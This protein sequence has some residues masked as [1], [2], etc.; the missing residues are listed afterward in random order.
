MKQKQNHGSFEKETCKNT[1]EYIGRK[2]L[3]LTF[4]M[5]LLVAIFAGGQFV[6]AKYVLSKKATVSIGTADYYF[7]VF[8]DRDEIMSL[9][10]TINVTVKNN[11]GTTITSADLTYALSTAGNSNLSVS[12]SEATGTLSKG[13]AQSKTFAVTIS[14]KSSAKKTINETLTIPVNVTKPYTDTKNISIKVDTRYDSTYV[15]ENPSELYGK[16]VTNY[17]CTNSGAVNNWLIFH[18]DEENIYLI[19]ENYINSSY[20]PK[21]KNGKTQVTSSNGY[22]ILIGSADYTNGSAD[23]TDSR[24]KKWASYVD[25]YSKSDN[26]SDQ[27]TAYMLDT[28]VWN[29]FEGSYASYAIGGPTMEMAVA[30][31]NNRYSKSYKAEYIKEDSDPCYNG[32]K[33][34]QLSSSGGNDKM[35]FLSYSSG[36]ILVDATWLASPANEDNC[37]MMRMTSSGW[38]SIHDMTDPNTG[39][40]PVVCL[41]SNVRLMENGNGTYSIEAAEMQYSNLYIAENPSEFY[42]KK[43]SNYKCTNS[44]A[45]NNWLIFHADEENIY[46]I[47][48]NY[49]NS[50]YM[51]KTKNGKTQASSSNG[52]EI[53][54]GSSDYANGTA[55]ITDSRVKK[56]A[57]YVDKYSKSANDSDKGTAYMLDTSVWNKFQGSYASYAIGGPTMEMAVASYNNRYSKSYKARY[58]KDST[59]PCYDGYDG[60]QLSSSGGNDQMYFLSYSSGSTLVNGTWLASP[61]NDDNCFMMM[62]TSSGS[63]SIHDMTD[64]NTGIR[65]V[66]CLNSNAKL[67][68]NSDGT[69]RIRM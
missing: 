25:Q 27:G 43:V 50:S 48:E 45:V 32:Y 46:L 42:G 64:P 63:C 23:I 57:S 16:K 58:I 56:W 54:I 55:D 59:N 1:E 30:S 49:I 38:C 11:N 4:I 8:A 35:Y 6:Y 7:E 62:M 44:G 39:I 40:R 12:C 34:L 20:M 66:V 69:Y 33:N 10:A 52:Y 28:S 2:V 5:T 9:P 21:T 41:N 14:R 15:A 47:S 29:G 51:P 68:K 37:F 36:S 31:Y 19:S 18:A 53:G 26:D 3:I 17:T 65:P 60:L 67:V 13:S 22:E 24:V 61:G